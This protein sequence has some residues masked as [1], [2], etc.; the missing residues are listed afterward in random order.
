M[1]DKFCS[2]CGQPLPQIMTCE[3]WKKAGED[4]IAQFRQKG[5]LLKAGLDWDDD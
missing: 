5:G 1:A 3:E 4:F 2:S